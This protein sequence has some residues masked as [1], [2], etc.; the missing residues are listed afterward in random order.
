MTVTAVRVVLICCILVM[1]MVF[2]VVTFHDGSDNKVAWSGL[3]TGWS[4]TPAPQCLPSQSPIRIYQAGSTIAV[5]YLTAGSF[6][7]HAGSG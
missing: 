6:R 1:E 3:L 7:D 5:M 2:M 4:M